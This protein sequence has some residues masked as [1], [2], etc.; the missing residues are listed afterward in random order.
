MPPTSWGADAAYSFARL[1]TGPARRQN[2]KAGGGSYQTLIN[3]ALLEH[4]H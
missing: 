4:I 2:M 1:I 3:D